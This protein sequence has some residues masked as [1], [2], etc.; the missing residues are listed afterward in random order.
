VLEQARA[1]L[2]TRARAYQ[3]IFL[4]HGHDTDT[5][6]GDLATFC[7]ASETT[8]HAD[9]RLSDV[10]IGRREV[11][12]RIAHH[13]HLTEDQLWNLYGNKTLPSQFDTKE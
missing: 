12:L 4:D 11:F 6:L 7:R 9:P 8:Y 13:L 3:R 2:W 5:V 10:L 1:F